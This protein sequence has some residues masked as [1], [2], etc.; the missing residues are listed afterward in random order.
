MRQRKNHPQKPSRTTPPRKQQRLLAAI[1]E[2]HSQYQQSSDLQ[3][4][5]T[6]L[7]TAVQDL[8]GSPYGAAG[9][10]AVDA[11]TQLEYTPWAS[12]YPQ[13]A[14][15][16]RFETLLAQVMNS[17]RQRL[18]AK[19]TRTPRRTTGKAVFPEAFL[20][21]PIFSGEELVAEVVGE[22]R[23]DVRCFQCSRPGREQR[24]CLLGLA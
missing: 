19:S 23:I 7:L 10:V 15:P 11:E 22:L 21:L 20:G 17:G 2:L 6:A 8:T 14:N 9:E 12:V 4:L 3:A 13:D 1:R 16:K 5:F 18:V 24:S